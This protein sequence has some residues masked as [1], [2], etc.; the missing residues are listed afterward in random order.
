MVLMASADR[1]GEAIAGGSEALAGGGPML[2]ARKTLCHDHSF[3]HWLTSRLPLP[4]GSPPL[5]AGRRAP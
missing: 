3:A 1:A 4:T 5:Q 2:A